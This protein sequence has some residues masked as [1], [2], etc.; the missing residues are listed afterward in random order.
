MFA[1]S[2]K[3]F[4]DNCYL[5]VSSGVDKALAD[6]VVLKRGRGGHAHIQNTKI[7]CGFFETG[8]CFTDG[9]QYSE[10]YGSNFAKNYTGGVGGGGSFYT[11]LC[12]VFI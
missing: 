4:L 8:F 6:P 10:M 2:A 5:S 11:S 7:C 1:F 9:R 12:I 3:I